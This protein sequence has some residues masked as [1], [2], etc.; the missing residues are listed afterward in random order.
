M[1]VPEREEIP[2]TR[3]YPDDFGCGPMEAIAN[4]IFR[5]ALK[6]EPRSILKTV[7]GFVL[8]PTFFSSVQVYHPSVNPG[9]LNEPVDSTARIPK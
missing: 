9:G 7:L 1:L 2:S 3:L 4:Q 8:L 6:P 5:L